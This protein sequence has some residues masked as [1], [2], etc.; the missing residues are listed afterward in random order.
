MLPQW[1][2]TEQEEG[3]VGNR[4]RQEEGGVKE[5]I[6]G[7]FLPFLLHSF[8]FAGFLKGQIQENL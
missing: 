6:G 3:G 5:K 1:R 7:A 2:R 8:G 4:A